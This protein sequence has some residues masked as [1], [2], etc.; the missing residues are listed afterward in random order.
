ME[1]RPT[2]RSWSKKNLVAIA[3]LPSI[4]YIQNYT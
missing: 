3:L 2:L 4:T 1:I